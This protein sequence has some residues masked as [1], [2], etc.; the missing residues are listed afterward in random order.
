MISTTTFATAGVGIS[1]DACNRYI[2]CKKEM[3][4]WTVYL[5]SCDTK[6]GKTK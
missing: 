2:L 1:A 4:E 3:S 5:S 6:S